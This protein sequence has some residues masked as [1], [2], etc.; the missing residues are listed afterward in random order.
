MTEG[1]QAPT[2]GHQGIRWVL[3][4]DGLRSV[5][6]LRGAPS[7]TRRQARC[8][9][10]REPVILKLGKVLIAHAAHRPHSTCALRSGEGALH[11]N[12]KHAICEALKRATDR[13]LYMAL[14]CAGAMSPALGLDERH[15]PR[16]ADPSRCLAWVRHP[17]IANWDHAEVEVVT[18]SRR[19]DVGLFRAGA[20]IG[21]VEVRVS[22]AVDDEKATDLA[23]G[24]VPW[25]EVDALQPPFIDAVPWTTHLPLQATRFGPWIDGAPPAVHHCEDHLPEALRL[26]EGA[27]EREVPALARLVDLFVHGLPTHERRCAVV[28]LVVS[29]GAAI[30]L[31]A[32]AHDATEHADVVRVPLA[33]P[34]PAPRGRAVFNLACDPESELGAAAESAW[35]ALLDRW[36]RQAS[37]SDAFPWAPASRLLRAWAGESS[38]EWW[39]VRWEHKEGR[40][41]PSPEFLSGEWEPMRRTRDSR[42]AARSGR[43]DTTELVARFNRLRRAAEACLPVETGAL[44]LT[45]GW[46]RSWATERGGLTRRWAATLVLADAARLPRDLVARARHAV[47]STAPQELQRASREAKATGAH[48]VFIAIVSAERAA[49]TP[50]SGS[51]PVLLLV[52]R[53]AQTAAAFALGNLDGGGPTGAAAVRAGLADG[54]LGWDDVRRRWRWH[55][56]P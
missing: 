14:P 5:D 9:G 46:A 40:W 33:R 30:A 23:L 24:A 8:P 53:E 1:A 37:A 35:R 47:V 21:A 28:D 7:T 16:D 38:G 48:A 52:E 34:I 11:F 25:I 45:A 26:A 44:A 31:Q 27:H 6:D 13:Q 20:L 15:Y 39:P 41:I 49:Q 19:V 17:L 54:S 43:L 50:S 2:W 3:V 22:H 32:H 10:C 55:V 36:S 56:A 29:H 42:D 4:D 51:P 12:T 18:P